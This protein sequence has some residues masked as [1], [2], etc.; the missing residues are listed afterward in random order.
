MRLIGSLENSTHAKRFAAF[1]L[2]EGINAHVEEDD[3][4]WEVWV[5]DE[6]QLEAGKAK[7]EKFRNEPD[8][9]LY[10]DVVAKA[11]TIQ[12]EKERKR[13]E[14]QKNVQVG[15]PS[16]GQPK[17]TP[18]TITLIAL[19]GIVALMTNFG[20]DA[21]LTEPTF[22]ALAYN[23]L[24]KEP[25]RKLVETIGDNPRNPSFATLEKQQV[26]QASVM[27]GQI[28]RLVTPMFI[29]FG[30]L[31]LVFNMIWLFQ[32]G[33]IV[34]HRYGTLYFGLLVLA[35]AVV[36]NFAQASVPSSIGGSQPEMV[37]G[38]LMTL[39]G[40]MSG[41]VFGLLGFIWVKSSSDPASGMFMPQ[42]TI[43]IMLAY[44]F[45]CMSPWATGYFA[46]V[47]NWAHGIGLLM[48]MVAAYV[49]TSI[50]R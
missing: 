27:K 12:Q 5:K 21:K 48:G 16:G 35:I 49:M 6:D 30:A 9:A 37:A 4:M 40:G 36:S 50:K 24:E 11:Q 22:R 2:T 41:V 13:Q 45:F 28:W 47:A 14:Y 44:M 39:F 29:H 33:R 25:A 7:L 8:A 19:C 32:L 34:E 15:A 46:N 43:M 3:S 18:L 20:A 42:S 17:K 10:R 26:I 38:Y 1:L 23:A 31:H